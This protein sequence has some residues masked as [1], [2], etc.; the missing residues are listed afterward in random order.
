MRLLLDTHAFL[1][2]VTGDR[3]LSADAR[4][5][6]KDNHAELFVSAVSVW[7]MAI[8]MSLGRLSVPGSVADYMAEKVKDGFRVL[9]LEWWHAVKVQELPF[10]HNDPFDRAIIAQ[11]V[12]EKMPLVSGDRIFAQYPVSL[13][14]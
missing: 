2:F 1:W 12:V 9:P 3:R 10:H 14:W 13:V 7:E 6:L 5:T 4:R 8:K 11:A